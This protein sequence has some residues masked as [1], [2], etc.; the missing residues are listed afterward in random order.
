MHDLAG[1]VVCLS[2][3]KLTIK[4]AAAAGAFVQ[5]KTLTLAA[6]AIASA[7]H[8]QAFLVLNQ[9]AESKDGALIVQSCTTWRET[10][11]ANYAGYHQFDEGTRDAYGSFEVYQ[12]QDG[13]YWV[14]CF[15]GCLPDGDDVGPFATAKEAYDDAAVDCEP[16]DCLQD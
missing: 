10:M 2:L 1:H 13:W 3:S 12:A 8:R 9:K 4:T 5:T 7:M 14:A 11:D 6:V 15:P 16:Q